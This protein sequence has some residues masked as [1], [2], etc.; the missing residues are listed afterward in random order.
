MNFIKKKQCRICGSSALA[1]ILNLG[2]M[3]LANAFLRA[4]DLAKEERKFPLVVY[5]C[6]N[7]FLVQLLGVVH[8][9]ILFEHY[10]YLTS[11]SAPLVRHFVQAANILAKKF[12]KEK[13]DLALE[14]GGNDGVLLQEMKKHCNVLNIEPA[15]NVAELAKKSGVETINEFFTNALAGDVLKKYGRARLIIADNVMAHIDD[16]SDVFRGIKTL[17][18]DDGAFVFEVHWVGNLTGDGGFDQIYHEHLCYFSLSPLIRLAG[19]F[20]LKIF[21]IE[22][23]PVH[24]QS[25]RIYAGKNQKVRNSVKALLAQEKKLGLQNLETFLNFSKKVDKNKNELVDFLTS[26]KRK[27]AVIAGYGAPAKGNT[28]LNYCQIDNSTIDFISDTT[29]LKHGLWTPGS[30]IPVY[31]RETWPRK[32]DYFL[33]LAWNY[34]DSIIAKET[35]FRNGGGKFII[36][37]PEVRIV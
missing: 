9:K 36:P 4:E 32:P 11:T 22:L 31:S 2:E 20:G 23:L 16:L 17:L 24:G 30:H 18:S 8:P 28:L 27:K 33:L 21:D 19:K 29:P 3:P 12:I 6:K 15:K 13:S 37:V 10:R 26:L 5:F 7:C 34:A 14:I 35:D 25:M 1:E